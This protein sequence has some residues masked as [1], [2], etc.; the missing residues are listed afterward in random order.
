MN[1][2][3]YQCQCLKCHK[4]LHCLC[5]C[6]FV[7]VVI[8]FIVGYECLSMTLIKCLEGQKSQNGQNCKKNKK[9]LLGLSKLSKK[10]KI[11]NNCQQ[12]S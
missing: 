9:N 1:S 6:F 11:V 8:F 10:I 12:L 2:G 5:H 4:S 3:T 7:A